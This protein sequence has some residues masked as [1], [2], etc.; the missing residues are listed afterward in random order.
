[1]QSA[2]G[3]KIAKHD[4]VELKIAIGFGLQTV[5]KILKIE[6]QSA[7]RLPSVTSLDYKL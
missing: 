7:M 1:M 5:T 2:I 6:L 4:R 3:V